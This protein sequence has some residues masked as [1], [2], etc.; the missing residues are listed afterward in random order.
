MKGSLRFI[1]VLAVIG[2]YSVAPAAAAPQILAVMASLGPQQMRCDGGICVTD[3]TSYCLQRD[4]DVPNSGQPY[5]P[6]APEQF[7]LLVTRKDGSTVTV[8]ASDHVTFKSVRGYASV[9]AVMR[10]DV[11]ASLDAKSATIVVAPGAALIPEAVAGDPNP[12]SEAE[13]AFAT[14]SLREHGNEVFDTQPAAEAAA[15]V[16]RLA[17]TIVPRMPATKNSLDQL[18]QDVIDGMGPARPFKGDSIKRA[19][20]IYEWCQDRMSYHSMAGIKSCLEF[21]HDDTIMQLNKGYWESQPGY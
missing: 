16:N 9:K 10:R 8:P 12:I 13:V 7:S 17:T 21:K 2:M 3:F 6:A 1:G 15:I 19:R 20:G 11:L 4:R 14:K 5:I 18:W